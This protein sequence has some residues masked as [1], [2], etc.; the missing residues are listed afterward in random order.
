MRIYLA[1]PMRGI[2]DYNFPAFSFAANRLRNSGHSVFNPAEKG[3][4]AEL[5]KSPGEIDYLD[6]RRRVFAIDAEFICK[7]A[8]VVALLPGWENSLGA[9]AERALAEAIGLSI[10]VLGAEYLPPKA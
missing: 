9:R 10:W 1:G 5:E 7:E 8:E 6:F 4:E 2:P 3:E